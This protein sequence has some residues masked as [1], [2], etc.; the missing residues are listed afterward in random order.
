MFYISFKES[1]DDITGFR[2]EQ[3]MFLSLSKNNGTIEGQ[4]Y[5]KGAAATLQFYLKVKEASP[6]CSDRLIFTPWGT[7]IW[8]WA[9]DIIIKVKLKFLKIRKN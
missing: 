7:F 9:F 4:L 5:P 3:D 1:Y 6:M 2:K 8:T